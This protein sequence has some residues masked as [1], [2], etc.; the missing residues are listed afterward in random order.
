MENITTNQL[1]KNPT[2]L[3]IG[4]INILSHLINSEVMNRLHI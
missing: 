3:K 4:D 2:E 1:A